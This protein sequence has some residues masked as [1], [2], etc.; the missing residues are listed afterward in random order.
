MSIRLLFY[1]DYRKKV[2]FRQLNSSKL[3]KI[4]DLPGLSILKTEET[5]GK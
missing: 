2:G 4:T 3:Y 5:T 1:S